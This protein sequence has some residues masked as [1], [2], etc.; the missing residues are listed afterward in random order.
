[1]E[2]PQSTYDRV[3]LE[4]SLKPWKNMQPEY[5][6]QTCTH[7][8]EN[9]RNLIERSD[10][11]CVLMWTSDGCDIY[12]WSGNYGDQV[13]APQCVGFCNYDKEHAFD[14]ENRHY[15]INRAQPYM[16]N[17]PRVTYR[18]LRNIIRELKST[19]MRMFGRKIMVGATIDPGPEFAFSRFKYHRHPEVLTPEG[20][21]IMPMHFITHTAVLREDPRPYGGFPG[22]IPDGTPFG[23]FI[24]R[25][26]ESARKELGY[27]YIWFSNGFAYSHYPWGYRGELFFG[28][29]WET[30]KAG[31]VREEV[32]RFWRDFRAECDCPIEVRGT[33]FPVGSDIS[34]DGCSHKDIMDIGKLDRP[35]CNPPWG[36]RALGTEMVAYM[37]RLAET[38]T[39]RLPFRFYLNDP[40]FNS[41][42]WYDY[43]NRETFDIYV[44]MSAARVNREGG[45]DTPTDL[46]LLTI[47]TELGDLIRE[48]ANESTPHFLRALE[49]RADAV[50]PVVWV[51]P[52]DEY[53]DVLK[54]EP[55]K[56]PY[57]FA[58]D[59][60]MRSVVDHGLPLNTVASSSVFSELAE[61]KS[62]PDALYVAPAALGNWKY[63]QKLLDVVRKGGHVMLYGSL[64]HAPEE[65]L[66]MLKLSLAEPLEGNFEVE[67]TLYEDRFERDVEPP[68][69]PDPVDESVG[70]TYDE[71]DASPAGGERLLKHRALSD[72]GGLRA[73]AS[74]GS[75]VRV[76]ARRNGESRAYAVVRN[77]PAWN[78][79]SIAWIHGSC[80]FKTG[81]KTRDGEPGEDK[82]WNARLP[83][84]WPR[85]I[86][87]EQSGLEIV[88]E[89]VD[90]SV[91]PAYVFIK[92]RKGAFIFTGHKPNTTV[93]MR[94]KTRDGAPAFAESET[95]IRDGYACEN[96]GKTYHN[97]VRVFVRQDNGTVIVKELAARRV[98]GFTRHFSVANLEGAD[99]TIYPDPVSLADGN[100][101]LNGRIAG[102]K[103]R[104]D[105][106]F[107]T[108]TGRGCVVVRDYTGALYVTW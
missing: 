19:A 53:D 57:I 42:A 25:Q 83:F 40:W 26:M 32:N 27:D 71:G 84:S 34:T 66:G 38:R 43:Y 10:E 89:R 94:I 88:Q 87:A 15:R 12:E 18:D 29:E 74:D 76:S 13:S 92:R 24:G 37:S 63:Q 69:Y 55:E 50:G 3:V 56:L 61:R 101:R 70:R 96:F 8:F 95:R 21:K 52:F 93:S 77:D 103:D 98:E 51:Y 16:D 11:L 54:G 4:V 49:M 20:W 99:V 59:W 81:R 106:P 39:R 80:G 75:S 104:E 2:L 67:C 17:P 47:D 68:N 5:I 82:P 97:E 30:E 90:E 1:M 58:H 86:L 23:T 7:L 46:S 9:W 108:D 60:F 33:N 85:H 105:V 22:G 14:P 79:G 91:K 48:E 78:G 72:G 100:L 36:S 65:A 41:N 31:Q 35:P 64:D 107:E 73:V 6:R 44:P 102:W 28:Q 62:L 45:V